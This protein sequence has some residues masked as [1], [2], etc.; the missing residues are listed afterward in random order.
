MINWKNM[1]KCWLFCISVA[2]ATAW[3]ESWLNVESVFSVFFSI[4][5]GFTSLIWA[6]NRW[7]IF[8]PD[9]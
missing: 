4:L 7:N 8:L 9:D 3:V 1:A 2:V 6:L 5:A